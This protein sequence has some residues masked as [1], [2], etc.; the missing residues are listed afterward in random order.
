MELES[1][2]APTR[3]D[4][5]DAEDALAEERIARVVDALYNHPRHRE[6]LY[7]TLDFCREERA[8]EDAETFIEAQPERAQALQ[9]PYELVRFLVREG[10]LGLVRYDAE[11]CAIDDEREAQLR[12]QGADDDVIADLVARRTVTT[13]PA[14][15]AA[16]ELLA[17][18]RRIAACANNVPARR[19]A[20]V[21]L[22]DFCREPRSLDEVKQFFEG[23]SVLEPSARTAGQKLHAVYFIDRLNEAGGLVWDGSWV[24]T[25]AGKRYLAS[26]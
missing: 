22:L 13:A 9:T 17:P 12:E 24:T 8:F 6:L 3:T 5:N 18:E 26:V 14:G 25:E 23:D 2:V 15:L 4:M 19:A 11:G 1:T 16:V 20:F 21:R 7:K 10:G